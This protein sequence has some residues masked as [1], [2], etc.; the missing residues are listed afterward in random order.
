MIWIDFEKKKT[1]AS[2][3]HFFYE[4]KDQQSFFIFTNSYNSL[5]DLPDEFNQYLV[6]WEKIVGIYVNDLHLRFV[7]NDN[8]VVYYGIK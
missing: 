1:I 6:E 3:V 8:T 2:I 7:G 4:S 5:H